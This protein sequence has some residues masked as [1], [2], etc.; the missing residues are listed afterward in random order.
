VSSPHSSRNTLANL[1]QFN[2]LFPSIEP[3]GAG[4]YRISTVADIY[5]QTI[6]GIPDSLLTPPTETD[7]VP[8]S[9]IKRELTIAPWN[10]RGSQTTSLANFTSWADFYSPNTQHGDSFTA[11]ARQPLNNTYYD[12]VSD[13]LIP[14]G[15]GDTP[16]GAQPFQVENVVILTDGICAS[17]CSIFAEYMTRQAGVKTIVM[18]GRPVIGPMQAIGGTKGSLAQP[19][20]G[21]SQFS[22]DMIG[23]GAVPSSLLSKSQLQLPRPVAIT[24]GPPECAG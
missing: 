15:E 7:N 22:Q 17:A 23:I 5:G 24:I 3:Y 13:G 9:Y 11:N 6:E 20:A 4:R 21:L 18:G 14:Y 10:C 12:I 16:V 8:V 1:S 19:F 2:R